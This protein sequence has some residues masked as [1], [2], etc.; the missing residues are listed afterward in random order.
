[1]GLGASVPLPIPYNEINAYCS[2]KGITSLSDRER[3]LRFIS[4]LDHEWMRAHAEQAETDSAKGNLTPPPPSHSPPRDGSGR[5]PT[6]RT[7]V[8]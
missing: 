7:P 4:A 5:R 2:L 1:M 6:P 8:A 3:L